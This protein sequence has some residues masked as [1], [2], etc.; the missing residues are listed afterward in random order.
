M[1]ESFA[2]GF[3]AASPLIVGGAVA[4]RWRVEERLLGWI[5]AF[6][7][8]VLI[9]AVSFELVEEA[10]DTSSGDRRVALGLASRLR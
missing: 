9:S 5:M 2:W 4:L 7:G 10:F 3:L 1:L 6:G 8:G